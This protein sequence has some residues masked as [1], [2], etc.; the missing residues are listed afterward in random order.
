MKKIGHSTDF[1]PIFEHRIDNTEFII[2]V[3]EV[4]QTIEAG[5]IIDTNQSITVYT[6]N[7]NN[8]KT[9]LILEKINE[10]MELLCQTN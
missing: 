1:E 8:E 5:C 6:Q 4:L 3:G 2:T 9:L 7:R 10:L